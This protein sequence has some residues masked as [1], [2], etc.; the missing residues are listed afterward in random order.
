M[1]LSIP[2]RCKAASRRAADS[3]TRYHLPISCIK[4]CTRRRPVSRSYRPHR[5]TIAADR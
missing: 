3:L 2:E 1:P 4:G 5:A